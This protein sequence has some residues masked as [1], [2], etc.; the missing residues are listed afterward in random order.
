MVQ[1]LSSVEIQENGRVQSL[2]EIK[3]SRRTMMLGSALQLPSHGSAVDLT[4]PLT[5]PLSDRASGDVEQLYSPEVDERYES[6]DL[7]SE[8]DA[9][10]DHSEHSIMEDSDEVCTL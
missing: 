6:V 7:S 10:W 8:E 2:K 4:I 1:Q 3:K 9:V 5:P